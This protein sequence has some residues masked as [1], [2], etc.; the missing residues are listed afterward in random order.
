MVAR[1]HALRRRPVRE[2]SRGG[3]EDLISHQERTP[4]RPHDWPANPEQT[5]CRFQSA[6]HYD[7]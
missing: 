4:L 3:L 1:P 6:P 7:G 2:T 5:S